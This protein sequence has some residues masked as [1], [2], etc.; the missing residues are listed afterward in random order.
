MRSAILKFSLSFLPGLL[1]GCGASQCFIDAAQ[2]AC[3]LAKIDSQNWLGSLRPDSACA[4]RQV[5]DRAWPQGVSHFE[6]SR[7][8]LHAVERLCQ[9]GDQIVRMLDA[10]A[11][12]D[13]ALADTVERAHFGAHKAVRG[14][15]GVT[16][17]AVYIAQ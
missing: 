15:G 1:C 11:E 2:S 7:A 6:Q 12:T 17:Q 4:I 10:H 16:G 5:V 8:G 14:A 9:I 13:E 3:C